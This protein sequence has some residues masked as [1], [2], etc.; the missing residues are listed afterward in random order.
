MRKAGNILEVGLLLAF[1]VIIAVGAMTIYNNRKTSVA[2]LSKSHLSSELAVNLNTMSETKAEETIPYNGAETV[3]QSS[4]NCF[5][6]G[7]KVKAISVT[8]EQ[9]DSAASSITYSELKNALT[10]GS[11][12]DLFTLANE[13]NTSLNLGYD[14]VSAENINSDT[15]STLIGIFNSAD[16]ISSSNTEAKLYSSQVKALIGRH[17]SNLYSIET[18][19]TVSVLNPS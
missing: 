12:M 8:T 13:L 9:F 7:T 1:V 17:V 3:S 16:G 6:V 5:K 14:S 11:N 2:G 4:L 19:G 15:L 18:A 10:P